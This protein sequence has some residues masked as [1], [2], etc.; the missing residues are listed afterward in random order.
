MNKKI[1]ILLSMLAA[2][3]IFAQENASLAEETVTIQETVEESNK[4]VAVAEAP[5]TEESKI[6]FSFDFAMEASFNTTGSEGKLAF[7]SFCFEITDLTFGTEI[8]LLDNLAFSFYLAA[9][10]K[11][12]TTAA[13]SD[14]GVKV[15]EVSP[16]LGVG[17][18]FNPIE[19]VTL[20]L[21]LGHNLKFE[22]RSLETF[23]IDA[24][25]I[26]SAS[27]TY[28]NSFFSF[29][30]S[31]TFN[32][33]WRITE[34]EKTEV[35]D[36]NKVVLKSTDME[37]YYKNYIDNELEVELTFDFLNFVKEDLNTGLWIYNDL[38]TDHYFDKDSN[39]SK[40][41]FEN[42]LHAGLHTNPV[43][44]F[45]AKAAFYGDFL[46]ETDKDGKIAD[47]SDTAGLGLFLEVAFAYKNI[48]FAVSY[49]PVLYTVNAENPKDTSHEVLAAISLSF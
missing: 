27:I 14:I 26:A 12:E 30:V 28:E 9:P 15:T 34:V 13:D 33:L 39:F 17:L 32:P 48:G 44:W 38:V 45:A 46:F 5:N 7:D 11:L 29:S 43:E 21:G 24:G 10:M 22:P 41:S 16:E 40:C 4:T 37:D 49:K 35:K 19:S 47:G 6:S 31:D 2:L 25:L 1:F 23:S 8:A 42:E 18:S 3:N 20:D 36:E